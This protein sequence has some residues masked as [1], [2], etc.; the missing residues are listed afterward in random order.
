MEAAA[1]LSQ[2]WCVM[3]STDLECLA[4]WKC[5]VADMTVIRKLEH[6]NR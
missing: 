5:D 4:S 6:A 1:E 2:T 3:V